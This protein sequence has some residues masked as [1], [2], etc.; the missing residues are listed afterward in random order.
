MRWA[1]SGC[2]PA[3]APPSLLTLVGAQPP[4][5]A[6]GR[7]CP[8]GDSRPCNSTLTL[9]TLSLSQVPAWPFLW[10]LDPGW[11]WPAAPATHHHRFPAPLPVDGVVGLPPQVHVALHHLRPQ[12]VVALARLRGHSLSARVKP[13]GL[14]PQFGICGE[15]TNQGAWVRPP[16]SLLFRTLLPQ[17]RW[18]PLE[19]LA[20]TGW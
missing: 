6:R 18:K 5:Q 19:A 9:C 14:G 8:A 13:E 20:G 7:F 2:R 17:D 16:I 3:F 11:E 1:A 4:S 12:D 10:A 15:M